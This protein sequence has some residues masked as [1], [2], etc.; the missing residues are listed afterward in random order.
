[1]LERWG[2]DSVSL[3]SPPSGGGVLVK[4][5]DTSRENCLEL[6]EGYWIPERGRKRRP[7]SY[8]S[9]KGDA[10]LLCGRWKRRLEGLKDRAPLLH[11]WDSS[12]HP[13]E[14]EK[15]RKCPELG[16]KKAKRSALLLAQGNDVGGWR[17]LGQRL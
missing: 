1:M 14:R 10:S 11:S 16:K 15:K 8:F 2:E 9:E 13:L 3:L 6:E 7:A 4:G 17:A 5:E 12:R